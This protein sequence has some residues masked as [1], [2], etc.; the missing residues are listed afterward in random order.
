MARSRDPERSVL[1]RERI[2]RR[3]VSEQS[4]AEVCESEGVS[5]ASFYAWRRKLGVAPPRASKGRAKEVALGGFQQLVVSQGSTAVSVR[6][7]GN[8]LVEVAAGQEAALRV[9]VAELVRVSRQAVNEGS[10]C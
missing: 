2:A 7:P 8:I 5:V 9:V 3:G 4:T 10:P 6:L 1:W